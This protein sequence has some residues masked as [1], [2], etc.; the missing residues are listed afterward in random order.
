MTKSPRRRFFAWRAQARQLAQTTEGEV[1]AAAIQFRD[2]LDAALIAHHPDQ[3]IRPRY[4]QPGAEH[5]AWIMEESIPLPLR[6]RVVDLE[7]ALDP[8]AFPD[9]AIRI[10]AL[11][12]VFN[13][14]VAG[15]L[16]ITKRLQDVFYHVAFDDPD[17]KVRAWAMHLLAP[18]K[19]P[20]PED[21]E[22]NDV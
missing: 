15:V 22:G 9:P 19:Y 20:P 1:H 21:K 8:K 11:L 5:W 17:A 10:N 18:A 4:V 16:V 12:Q 2:A 6:V 13:A 7:T 14:I 3:M